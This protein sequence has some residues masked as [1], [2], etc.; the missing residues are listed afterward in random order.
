[1]HSYNVVHLTSLSW[2]LV[3]TGR[4]A[5]DMHMNTAHSLLKAPCQSVKVTAFHRG[6]NG[7]SEVTHLSKHHSGME[8]DLTFFFLI[9][10]YMSG[11]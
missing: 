6:G 11:A 2:A 1:M 7:T 10:Q 3:E 9:W 8:T 5:P 4:E